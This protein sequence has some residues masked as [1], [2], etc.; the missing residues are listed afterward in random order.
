MSFISETVQI[1]D[2]EIVIESGKWAK[3]ASGSIVIRIG[4]SM[5]LVTATG[6]NEARENMSFMPLSCEYKEKAYAAGNIPGGFF[7]REGRPTD[8]EVLS[9]RLIDRSLRPLFPS[10]WR[11]ETQVIAQT[12]SFDSVNPTDVLGIIG[13]SAALYCSDLIWD[14]PIAAVR[15][16]Y[17]DGK[18]VAFPTFDEISQSEIN[19]VVACSR[20][21]IMMVEGDMK[22]VSESLLIDALMFAHES[23]QPLIAAQDKIQKAVGKQ[24]RTHQEPEIDAQ[25]MAKIK[26]QSW[27]KL[28]KAFSIKSK[29]ERYAELDKI[30]S[31]LLEDFCSEGSEYEHNKSDVSE[32]FGSTKA[33][34][35]RKQTIEQKQ[36]V[37][38]RKPEE[39]RPISCEVDV[40]PMAHGSAVFTRGETQ[41]LVVATLGTTQDEQRID[42]L[43]DR[44]LKKRFMLHYNFLPFCTGE[45]KPIRGTSRR[46]VGH[47]C[48][49][50]R[51]VQ[52]VMPSSDKFPY[53]VRVVS[54]ILESN[55]SSSMA[56][57][58]GASL[59]LMQGGVPL[60]TPVAGIAMGLMKENDDYVILSDILG[61]EDHI[62]DMDFKVTGSKHGVCALQMDIKVKGL[63]RD[64]LEQALEQARQGRL[65]ILDCMASVLDAPHEELAPHAPR[66]TK[67]QI[68][69]NKI[70]DVI[71]PGGK[72]IRAIIEQTGAQI[73]ITDDGSVEVA[74]TSERSLGQVIDLIQ[75][76]TMEPEVGQYYDGVV[77][78]VV[79]FGAFVEIIPGTD[80]LIHI[81]ELAPDRIKTVTDVCDVGDE[82][83]VKVINVDKD[84]KIRLSRKAVLE[85]PA[86]PQ[87]VLSLLN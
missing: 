30:K 25:L 55:G 74:S 21:A 79:D 78:R 32:A 83:C 49:A 17:I 38:G 40:L 9:S 41:A 1:G 16:G 19:M 72:T 50:E 80:G 66:I 34:Y 39:I 27:S 33:N 53:T 44:D 36:R 8:T 35:A 45:A 68:N 18:L 11:V 12:I 52:Q 85:E 87:D 81:S 7:K 10:S 22:E 13:A 48:L 5:L 58:C 28:E 26:E 61:D 77:K 57:V 23:V 54:E 62:G 63:S 29:H 14:G 24:K 56:S 69:P 73:D 71:G 51:S 82:I 2:K 86:D 70:R 15:V 20:D 3:Q 47:G 31:Q 42:T 60:K 84:G 4:D 67:I 64:I 46:E 37:D 65:H 75:G 43:R 76:L 6:A 59:A